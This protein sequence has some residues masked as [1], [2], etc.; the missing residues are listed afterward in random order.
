MLT[1]NIN[2][3]TLCHKGSGGI[4]HNTLPDVCKT[5]PN[6]VPI[7]YDNEAYSA[8]LIKGT[9][10]VFADGENMIAN[11]GSQFARSVFDEP[12]KMGGIIS[13]TNQAEAEWISH[14]FDVFFE[15][16]PACRL[17]DKMFMNQRNTVNMA[18]LWQQDLP[19]G[20]EDKVCD[21]ICK[22]RSRISALKAEGMKG[23]ESL[24]RKVLFSNLGI[25]IDKTPEDYMS[26]IDE[27]AQR[28]AKEMNG[29]HLRQKCFAGEFAWGNP[30]Y[31]PTPKDP[32]YLVEVP[33]NIQSRSVYLS[34]G[35]PPKYPQRTTYPGGPLA[36]M[37][38]MKA[39]NRAS[40][41]GAGQIVIWDLVV[42]KNHA[43]PADWGNVSKI[44]EIKFDNDKLTNN[45]ELAI[46]HTMGEK[47]F[48]VDEKDC[49]CDD[50]DR[51]EKERAAKRL[52][53]LINAINKSMYDFWWPSPP[54]RP[55]QQKPV[56]I[57]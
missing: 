26:D 39:V 6:G 3:L 47:V 4:S 15:K 35:K 32:R 8:D 55:D 56:G 25:H 17:T 10:S 29:A 28:L 38:K 50:R 7:P 33:Y 16:K 12:G 52:R 36:P 13:G 1:I 34:E 54:S 46:E 18:G 37:S 41:I 21:A 40:K 9:I 31:G 23:L 19:P 45:Q 22:C 43:Y 57:F 5:P 51:E 27:H 48:V 2:G 30:D 53:N 49:K 20:L 14:S 42:L 24:L 44:L 11:L